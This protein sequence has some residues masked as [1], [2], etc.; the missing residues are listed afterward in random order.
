MAA[1]KAHAEQ[2]DPLTMLGQVSPPAPEILDRAREALWSAAAAEMLAPPPPTGETQTTGT[3]RE[4]TGTV[5]EAGSTARETGGTARE[6]G[7]EG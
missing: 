7:H 3:A 1:E 5:H 2:P 6:H 4:A